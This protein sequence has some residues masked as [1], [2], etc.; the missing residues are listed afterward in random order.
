MANWFEIYHEDLLGSGIL[1]DDWRMDVEHAVREHSSRQVLTGHSVTAVADHD[2]KNEIDVVVGSDIK[3]HIPWL[4]EI[5]STVLVS[6][7][8][9]MFGKRIYPAN[10]LISSVNINCLRGVGSEYEVHVDSNPVTGLLFLSTLDQKM[11]GELVFE[12]HPFSLSINP[13]SGI[14]IAFDARQV[15]HRVAPLL[16]EVERISIPMNF[17]DSQDDQIRPNDLD[18]YLYGGR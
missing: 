15:P 4:Y 3:L 11:G 7:V 5:Y 18:G 17:Y 12:K 8:S 10:D 13:V 14:F 9:E 16:Q 2:Y 1:P 6:L